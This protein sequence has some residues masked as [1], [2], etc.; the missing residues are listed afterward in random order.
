M[1]INDEC[2]N[3]KSGTLEQNDKDLVCRGECGATFN[4][5]WMDDRVQ[6]ARLLCEMRWDFDHRDEAAAHL[7]HRM[8][9]SG[10]EVTALFDRAEAVWEGAKTEFVAFR[11]DPNA[12][13]TNPDGSVRATRITFVTCVICAGIAGHCEH[14]RAPVDRQRKQ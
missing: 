2:P 4:P 1:N 7:C 12:D 13:Y 9:L 5:L 14:T 10:A 8:G 11:G 3:C 6:F